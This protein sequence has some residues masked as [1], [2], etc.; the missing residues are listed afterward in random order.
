MR[1]KLG[2]EMVLKLK[3]ERENAFLKKFISEL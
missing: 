2:N 3:F 1:K